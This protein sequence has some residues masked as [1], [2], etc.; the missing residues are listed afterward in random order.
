MV[1]LRAPSS[2]RGFTLIEAIMVITITGIIASI[3]AVFIKTSV[4]SYL[5]TSRRAELTEAADVALRKLAREVRLAVPNSL[6]LPPPAACPAPN[7][8]NTCNYLEFV[9]TK[10]GGR[11]RN[12]GDGSS[13][14]GIKFLCTGGSTNATFDVLGVMPSIVTGDFIVVYNDASLGSLGSPSNVYGGG[15]RAATTNNVSPLSIGALT[16]NTL[17]CSY[18]NNRFQVV[19]KNIR[20]VTYACPTAV[21]GTMTRYWNYGFNAV[22]A[23][24][25][26][27]SFASAQVVQNATCAMNYTPNVLQRNG[28]LSITLTVTDG[29]P[30]GERIVAFREIHVDNAP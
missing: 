1:T 3:V 15:S 19:D 4:D 9:P 24:P 21:A 6:R 18:A 11:Y 27:G 26:G 22:Q 7:A 10:D 12:E 20:A 8:A 28:L 23:T 30:S 25:P 2:A 14:P 16:N 5:S 29:T 17:I 13:G